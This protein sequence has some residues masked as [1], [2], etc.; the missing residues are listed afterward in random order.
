MRT[1]QLVELILKTNI[2]ARNSDKELIIA[3]L[4]AIGVLLTPNQK[5][6]IHMNASFETIRRIRQ[7]LQEE[8]MYVAHQQV[9]R[10]RNIKSQEI[11]Q[12]IPVT[13]AVKVPQLFGDD[14]F[15]NKRQV[16]RDA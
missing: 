3:Y 6:L 12:R 2:G 5:E 4:E 8:G 15:I 1:Q 14:Q 11:Q 10:I 7:K 13:K 16:R 9:R